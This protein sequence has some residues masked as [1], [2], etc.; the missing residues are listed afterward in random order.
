MN[1]HVHVK[2]LPTLDWLKEIKNVIYE[3][4]HLKDATEG[5]KQNL[6]NYAI[7]EFEAKIQKAFDEGREFQKDYDS[8][9]S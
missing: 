9:K 2:C 6:V 3:A 7:K 1:I 4:I 8:K 5:Q